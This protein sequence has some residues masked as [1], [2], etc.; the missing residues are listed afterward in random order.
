MLVHLEKDGRLAL[1]GAAMGDAGHSCAS[2]LL[3]FGRSLALTVR[4][5]AS[6]IASSQE[7]DNRLID[8]AVKT[9]DLLKAAARYSSAGCALP[10]QQSSASNSCRSDITLDPGHHFALRICSPS[11]CMTAR[12]CRLRQWP[13]RVHPVAEIVA[14][15]G[16]SPSSCSS[17]Q[18]SPRLADPRS[19]DQSTP[20]SRAIQLL[21]PSTALNGHPW[22]P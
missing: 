5:R 11:T 15:P 19:T 8:V 2:S 1:N 16:L 7:H 12:P 18:R 9:A 13:V 21:S 17:G 10:W 6:L 14:S 3:G 22:R 4:E 20:P